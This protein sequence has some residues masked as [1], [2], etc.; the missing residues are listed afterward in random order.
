MNRPLALAASALALLPSLGCV[1]EEHREPGPPA[2]APAHGYRRNH[3]YIYYPSST[4]YFDVEKKV[5]FFMDA[6][7]WK[8]SVS[9]PTG[10]TISAAEGVSLELDTDTPYSHFAEHQK[11]YPP[12]QAKKEAGG[13]PGKGGQPEGKGKGKGKGKP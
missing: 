4:C 13:N 3:S 2:H 6:G 1:V 12:G 11:M 8:T 9:I 5:Y 7:V 10:I